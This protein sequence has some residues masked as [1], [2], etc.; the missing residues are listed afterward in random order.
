[1]AEEPEKVEPTPV[2][3]TEEEAKEDLNNRVNAFIKEYG[4]LVMRHKVDFA[5]YPMFV[6]DG[7]GGFKIITQSTPVDIGNQPIRSDFMSTK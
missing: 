4:E 1:M 3:K 2:E 6:P 5:T 7:K